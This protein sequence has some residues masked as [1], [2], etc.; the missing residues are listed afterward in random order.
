VTAF[1]CPVCGFAGLEEP[2]WSDAA[3]SDE[4]CPSCGTHF[5]FD[6]A[7][8]GDAAR[9]EARHRELRERWKAAGCPWFSRATQPPTS[10]DPATQLEV[11]DE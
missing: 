5:G 9:R 7:A 6:D 2:P 3:P 11:F 8:K 4:I 1:L 10:W